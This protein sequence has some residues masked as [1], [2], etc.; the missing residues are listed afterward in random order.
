LLRERLPADAPALSPG[1]IVD[2]SGRV[3]GRHPGVAGFTLGQRK[4]IGVALGQP[5]YV[6]RTDVGKRLVV[7]GPQ[8]GT[9][10][11]RIEAEEVTWVGRELT[12]GEELSGRAQIRAHG[13]TTPARV[14]A[15]T[16][17]TVEVT[18]EAPVSAV[19]SGQVLVVY[20]EDDEEVLLSA[21][22]SHSE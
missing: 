14:R 20:G 21:W 22:I 19:A 17:E 6:Q 12:P 2:P 1:E 13:S 18:L 11:Q 4:G 16:P 7:I 15:L 9:L 10:R 3:V 5:V 8:E